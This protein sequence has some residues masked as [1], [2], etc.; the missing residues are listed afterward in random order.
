MVVVVVI[1]VVNGCCR[2]IMASLH[3]S[4]PMIVSV[5]SRGG[6][7]EDTVGPLHY[8]GWEAPVARVLARRV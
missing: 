6:E 1:H 2:V 5:L 3:S 7:T 4:I 8:S